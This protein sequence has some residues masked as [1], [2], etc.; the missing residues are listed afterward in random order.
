MSTRAITR[1]PA[2]LESQVRRALE[3]DL[4]ADELGADELGAGDLSA[5]LVPPATRAQGTLYCREAAVLCGVPWFERSFSLLA[6]TVRYTWA[7]REGDKLR[8][9]QRVCQLRGPAR[10]L[11]SGERTALNFLQLLSA[12]ATATSRFAQHKAASPVRLLDTRKTLP[13]LRSAQKYAVRCGGGSNHR[14][15]LYDA[16]LLKE[17]HLA[18]GGGLRTL[19]KRAACDGVAVQVEVESLEQ[20]EDALRAGARSILLDN[21]SP[22]RVRAAVRRAAGRAVLEVSGAVSLRSMPG[23][24]ASGV[25]RISVGALTKHVRAVDFSLRLE[26]APP[27]AAEKGPRCGG[28]RR[29]PV[30]KGRRPGG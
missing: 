2:D 22:R 11:L 8:A 4:G 25:P 30:P 3:E 29:E 9:G 21:F 15:G 10:A 5:A 12:T 19:L 13:G 1:P 6:P 18:V 27:R 24:V 7:A 28:G 16:I 14:M 20:L 26:L 23:L 17:N